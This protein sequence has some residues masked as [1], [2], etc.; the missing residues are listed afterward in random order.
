MIP[1][2]FSS[3]AL[4]TIT[5]TVAAIMALTSWVNGSAILQGN[6][7]FDTTTNTSPAIYVN[8]LARAGTFPVTCTATGGLTGV[9]ETCSTVSPF[10]TT[11]TLLGVGL[12]CG[13]VARALQGDVSFKKSA[14]SA[15]G[16]ALTNLDGVTL[17]TGSNVFSQ[18]AVGVSWNPADLLTFSTR[19]TPTGTLNTTRY[20]CQMWPV[21]LDKYGS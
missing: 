19:A 11:G 15:T 13:N 17:G 16:T 12:E 2:F 3:L 1:T 21:Y 4:G 18:L 7:F 14:G 6:L 8:T 9:Y 5:A 10:T 20:N